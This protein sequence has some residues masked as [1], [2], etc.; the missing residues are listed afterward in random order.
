MKS[1]EDDMARVVHFEIHAENPQRAIAFYRDLF[2][3]EFTKWAGPQ[4]YWVIKTGPDSQ[5]GIN[6][7]M[8]RRRGAIDGT[9]VIAYVCT[10][11]VTSLDATMAKAGSTGGTLVVPKMPIPGLGWLAYAKDTEGNIF[12][13][14]QPDPNAK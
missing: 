7:G 10:I 1:R 14:M 5:A 13:V 2:G 6:G 8:I 4:E 9:A 12:G 3:W 11:E